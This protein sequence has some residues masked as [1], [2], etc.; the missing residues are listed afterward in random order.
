MIQT[1]VLPTGRCSFRRLILPESFQSPS[2][3]EVRPTI[4]LWDYI[5]IPVAITFWRIRVSEKSLL[6][7]P[8]AFECAQGAWN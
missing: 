5:N 2:G 1:I 6:D 3:A 8:A 7:K 4:S